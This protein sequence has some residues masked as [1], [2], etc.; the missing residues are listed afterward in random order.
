MR[1]Q[2]PVEPFQHARGTALTSPRVQ[3]AIPFE[4]TCRS[5]KPAVVVALGCPQLS[6]EALRDA[7]A[8]FAAR[9]DVFQAGFVDSG[10]IIVQLPQGV[11]SADC[12]IPDEVGEFLRSRSSRLVFSSAAPSVP[13]GPYFIRGSSLHQAWRLY[14]DDMLSFVSAVIPADDGDDFR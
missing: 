8:D 11:E 6:L 13:E 10:T 4:N 12:A 1:I 3:K 7:F 2:L 9:D 5:I 14:E